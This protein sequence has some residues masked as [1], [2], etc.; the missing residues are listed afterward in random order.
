MRVRWYDT[1]VARSAFPSEKNYPY[2]EPVCSQPTLEDA[3]IVARVPFLGRVWRPRSSPIHVGLES[4]TWRVLPGRDR[5]RRKR[6]ELKEWLMTFWREE[7]EEVEGQKAE[8]EW[9][10]HMRFG[11]EPSI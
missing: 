6:D 7:D 5:D 9:S 2:E 3:S 4:R 11:T 1:W 10:Y 8:P